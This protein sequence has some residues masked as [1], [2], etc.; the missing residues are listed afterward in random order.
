[1]FTRFAAIGVGHD[2]TGMHLQYNHGLVDDQS[3]TDG[4]D[5]G[6]NSTKDTNL[7]HASQKDGKAN[8]DKDNEDESGVSTSESDT[9]DGYDDSDVNACF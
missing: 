9:N 1:M 6:I 5:D 2:T 3:T 4:E 8:E 7:R